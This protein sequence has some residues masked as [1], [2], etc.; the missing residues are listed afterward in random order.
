MAQSEEGK[1]KKAIFYFASDICL[2]SVCL[3]SAFIVVQAVRSAPPPHL[4]RKSLYYLIKFK[5][6]NVLDFYL[7]NVKK[8]K[9]ISFFG[10]V[11]WECFFFLN[12]LKNDCWIETSILVPIFYI[13]S[14]FIFIL[15]YHVYIC[16]QLNFIYRILKFYWQYI[17]IFPHKS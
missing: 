14:I 5:N 4:N 6:T 17:S 3:F 7:N 16:Y 1:K 9:E 10:E 15:L 8:K 13:F 11:T 2:H 12:I